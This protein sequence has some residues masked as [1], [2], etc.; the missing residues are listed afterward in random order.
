MAIVTNKYENIIFDLGGV[1]LNIDT[2]QA[3]KAFNDFGVKN[4]DTLVYPSLQKKLTDSYEKG[5]ISTAAF[6]NEIKRQSKNSIDD[7]S[8]DKAWNSMLLDFPKTRLDLLLRLKQTHRT[9]LLSNTNEIH[10]VSFNAYLQKNYKIADL[11]GCFE[12]TYLSYKLGMSKPDPEIFKLVL[13]ENKLHPNETLFIDD[14]IQHIE[15]AK[16]LGIQT[17]WLDVKKESILDLFP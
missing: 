3:V 7:I 8:I 6:R 16:K 11:S 13:S 2:S 12:K 4:F 14:S 5:Q 17:Y 9:F 15:G 1:L 10:I